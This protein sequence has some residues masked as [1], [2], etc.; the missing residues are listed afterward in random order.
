MGNNNGMLLEEHTAGTDIPKILIFGSPNSGK[1]TLL[2]YFDV[3]ASSKIVW[4]NT[5]KA[6]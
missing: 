2:S 6:N 3:D 4:N 1:S 5:R